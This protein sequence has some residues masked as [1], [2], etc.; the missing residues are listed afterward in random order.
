MV[1]YVNGKNMSGKNLIWVQKTLTVII[2]IF[3]RVSLYTNPGKTKA[4]V[5]TC[6]IIFVCVVRG[7][8]KG[9]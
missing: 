9:H 2:K 1:F 6:T 3:E 8:Y 5:F 7:M 4:M